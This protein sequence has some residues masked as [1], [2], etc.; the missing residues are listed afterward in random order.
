MDMFE[1]QPMPPARRFVRVPCLL[2]A[3]VATI[4]QSSA[5]TTG[6][7][8]NLLGWAEGAFTVRKPSPERTEAHVVALDGVPDTK[9]IGV[10]RHSPLPHEFVIELPALTTFT[11]FAVPEIGEF[12]PAKGRHVKTVEIAASTASADGGFEPLASFGIEVG[13][14]AAQEF[15]VP[16]PRPAR[17]LKVRF[18]DRYT[19]QANDAD[20]VLFSE[21]MGYGKQEE[22]KPPERGF[23]GIWTLRRGYDISTNLIELHQGEG[24]EVRGCQVLGGQ[25]STISGAV[26]DGMLRMVATSIQGGKHVSVP[27]I[28]TITSEGELHGVSSFHGGL[29]AFS[30]VPAPTGTKTPCSVEPEPPNPVDAALKAGLAAVIYGI[31]F[32]LDSDVL[33]PD[34]APALE[35][36]RA[37]LEKNPAIPVVIEGHTDSDGSDAHNLDLSKRRAG[38]VVA[39]LV[40]KKLDASRMQAVGKGETQPVA[41]NQSAVGR[42]MNRRVEVRAE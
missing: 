33:R 21:L 2:C 29:R 8:R 37:A 41:D 24:G 42:A 27:A 22:R 6:A 15:A 16:Q 39:W 38:A 10:P 35:Q 13:K 18:V 32:D 9:S 14:K 11:R 5:E 7:P 25:Q 23:E 3:I 17:W 4:G 30:G 28:A 12:G 40:G 19:P 36:L 1:K 26:G 34:A 31:H 20:P